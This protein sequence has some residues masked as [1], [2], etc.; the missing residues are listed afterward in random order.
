MNRIILIGN[1]FDLAH[2]LETSYN[3]FIDNYWINVIQEYRNSVFSEY[4]NSTVIFE[5]DDIQIITNNDYVVRNEIPK[6][7]VRFDEFDEKLKSNGLRINFKN[8]LLEKITRKKSIKNWVDIEIEYFMSMK[9]TFNGP[10]TIEDINLYF[11]KIKKL[12]FEYLFKI[13]QTFIEESNPKYKLKIP[14]LSD[15]IYSKINYNEFKEK[16]LNKLIDEKQN[17]LNEERDKL[18]NSFTEIS[19]LNEN[20]LHKYNYIS[21]ILNSRDLKKSIRKE[22]IYGNDDINPYP[23]EILFLSFNYTSVI[24]NYTKKEDVFNTYDYKPEIDSIQ[25]HGKLLD[26]DSI[27]FGFDNDSDTD[28]LKIENLNDDEYL[29]NIK[30]FMYLEEKNYNNLINFL[31]KNLFEVFVL[32]HSCGISDKTLLK[33]IFENENCISIKPFF[34][35]KSDIEDNFSEILKNIYRN[36]DNKFE[37]RDKVVNK[38]YCKKM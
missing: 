22:L 3:D 18:K 15:K 16:S 17:I 12:L 27:I 10:Y 13:N 35:K 24:N 36:F 11:S 7:I 34:Y 38:T 2:N 19:E 6:E 14:E 8:I 28:F 26:Y 21:K 25:I 23:D 5:N 29:K 20:E 32:G 37:M 30:T 4:N 9:D 31:D 1:G 33:T